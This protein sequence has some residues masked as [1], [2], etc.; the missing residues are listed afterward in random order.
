MNNLLTDEELANEG[1]KKDLELILKSIPSYMDIM[2]QQTMM[3]S[4]FFKMGRSPK[5]ITAK[6]VMTLLLFSQNLMQSGWINKDAFQQL[7]YFGEDECKEAK[8]LLNNMTLFKFCTQPKEQRQEIYPKVLGPEHK[9]KSEEVEKCID[10][11]P[12]VKLTMKAF[13]EGEDEIVV[14]DILTCRLEVKYHNLKKGQKSGYVHSKTYPYLKRDNWFI[15][16]TDETFTGL[17]AVEKITTTEDVYVKE[18]KER[19]QRPGK[20]SF[21]A[22]LVNDSFKGLD[23]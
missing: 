10:A 23:Q 15:I 22:V 9:Q 12:L 16:I 19:I 5:R 21:T 1:L 18:F 14:G 6:N 4:Q 7:P 17:A 2:L 3:L 13:V 8:K 20:I 11:L